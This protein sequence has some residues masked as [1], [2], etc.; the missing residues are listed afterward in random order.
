MA[1]RV[2]LDVLPYPIATAMRRIRACHDKDAKRLK[3][4]LQAAEMTARFLAIVVL[5]DLRESIRAQR[6]EPNEALARFPDSLRRPSF[7]HWIEIL[8]EGERL[9]ADSEDAFMPELRDLVFARKLGSPGEGLNLLQDIVTVR[10]RFA[11]GDMGPAEIAKSCDELE[12]MMAD[13]LRA[14]DFIEDYMPYYVK[15]VN[16]HRRRLEASKFAHQFWLLA[17]AYQDPEAIFSEREWHTD[18]EDFILEKEGGGFLNLHPLYLYLDPER[19]DEASGIRPD[20][21]VMNGFER[22]KQ[23]WKIHYLPCGTS[24]REFNSQELEYASE[25][26]MAERGIEELLQLLGSATAEAQTA[27]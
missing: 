3:Y 1:R 17:G 27:D 21:Y 8:R 4:V 6:L 5:A 26:E 14:M 16:V 23:G 9:L 18:T 24:G 20:L 22:K 12:A 13:L 10:N 25:R 2:N 7:G 19:Y 15:T 11:H